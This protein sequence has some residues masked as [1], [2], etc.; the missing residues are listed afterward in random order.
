MSDPVVPS[1]DSELRTHVERVLS[2]LYEL[3]CEIGRGGMGVVYRA[4]DRRLKRVVAIKVLPP[5]LAFRSEIKTRFLREAETAAQLN[6]PNIVDIYAVDEIEG[7]V[8]FVM[9]YIMGDNLAKRVHDHGALSVDETR[10]TMRDVADA[11]AYAHERGVIHRDIKPDNI[12][13]D[14]GSGRP[15]VTD[16]GIAR[17]ITEGD[18]RLTATGIAIGTPTYMSPEQAAGER[19]VDGRSDLYSLGILGYQMLTGEPPFIAN[20]TPAI[21]VKHIS[22]RPVPVDQRRADVPQDLARI[23][24]TLLEKDPANRFP[25]ANA[26]VQALD[27]GRMPH[28]ERTETPAS[29]DAASG[30]M[31]RRSS[32]TPQFAGASQ[33]NYAAAGPTPEEWRRWEAPAVVAFRRKIAPYLFVNGV[34]VI[35]SIVGESDFFG[36]TVIWSIYLAFKY[37]KLWADGYDWRDVFRQPR[38]RDLIDVADDAMTYARGMF[39]RDQRKVMRDQRRSRL[40]RPSGAMALPRNTGVSTDAFVQSAGKYGDR[41]RR[42]ELDRDEILRMLERMPSAERS[43]I[44]DVGRS[45]DALAEKV[46]YL[47]LALAD[48]DRS[49]GPGGPAAIEAEISVLENAANPLDTAG[50]EERVRRLAHLK[51][52]RRALVETSGK[53]D[54]VAAKLDTCVL[55]LQNIKLDLMRLAAGAQTP[56]HI[57]SLAMDALNLAESVDSALYV[58]DEMGRNTGTRPAAR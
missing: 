15:M 11:L 52:Q 8:Y 24:M 31:S 17:A 34:I 53:R 56:Q 50:S 6:H 37:A 32:S 7:I 42:A 2:P 39:N 33:D 29:S 41:I 57:T 26:V 4:K 45:A 23:I 25:S 3:D 51:R 47:S 19:T 20:S 55:A 9:A 46:K 58:S 22:E 18:S 44:P 36:F 28:I 43:R 54:A 12:L 27:T 48:L 21:L 35:A 38:D 16:F 30:T 14:Q 49:A 5:E 40:A 13:I 10:R 1:S